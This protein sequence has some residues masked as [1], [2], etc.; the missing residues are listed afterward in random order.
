MSS[1]EI[2]QKVTNIVPKYEALFGE[3]ERKALKNM[4]GL[5]SEELIRRLSDKDIVAAMS[6]STLIKLYGDTIKVG[7]ILDTRLPR[8]D[9]NKYTQNNIIAIIKSS[10]GLPL[11]RKME[12]L[13][14]AFNHMR[15]EGVDLEPFRDDIKESLGSKA[16]NKL[17]AIEGEVND[18]AN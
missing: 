10:D 8:Q 16:T 7:I 13:E 4:S 14:K 9:Q 2:A 3:V 5:V 18:N 6:D 11:D 1:T 17:L 12:V 15:D